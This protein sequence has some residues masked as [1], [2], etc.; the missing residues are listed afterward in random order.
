MSIPVICDRCRV[1]GIAGD[2]DFSHLG[3]LL[4]FEPV[5]RK[6]RRADGWSP[7]K[8]RAFIAALSVTGSKRQAARAVG[9]ASYGV[10]QMLKSEGNGS[11]KAAVERAMAIAAQNG[12][13]KIAQG[14]ADAAARNAQLTPPSRLRD[15]PSP[16]EGEVQGEGLSEDQKWDLIH[17]IGV[18]FMKKVAQER[19][20]RLAGEIVAADFYLRQITMIE[21]TL[22]LASAGFGFDPGEVLRD[23]RRGEHGILEIA[24]TP[25]TD[26]LD[27]ARRDWW[28]QEGEPDRPLYPDV[29]FLK[30]HRSAE[31]DYATAEQ[32]YA[33][34]GMRPPPGIAQEE[35]DKMPRA[36]QQA[37][38]A[39]VHAE[40]AAAQAEWERRAIAEHSER[41]R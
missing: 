3:D 38:I 5:P 29:R 1:T 33:C 35:W 17:S 30:R 11:F 23:L 21:V 15:L 36:E 7:E 13:M 18:K 8:Q 40:D 9:M 24:S 37:L 16:F 19:E 4:E 28:R 2:A 10:D 22:D 32:T 34:A 14:V 31:G 27:R 26:W 25:L 12:S 41:T 39:R 6:T 20:A